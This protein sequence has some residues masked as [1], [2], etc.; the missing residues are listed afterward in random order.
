MII[1]LKKKTFFAVY[2]GKRKNYEVALQTP[3]EENQLKAKRQF[4]EDL[5]VSDTFFSWS[6]PSS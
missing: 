1:L 6:S 2:L 3:E 4:R 5:K